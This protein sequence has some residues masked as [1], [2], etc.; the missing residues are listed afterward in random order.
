MSLETIRY[1]CLTYFF[2]YSIKKFIFIISLVYKGETEEIHNWRTTVIFPD[3]ENREGPS[4]GR[5]AQYPIRQT[6][7]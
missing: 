7:A 2:I 5:G 4:T 1:H 6:P 3:F